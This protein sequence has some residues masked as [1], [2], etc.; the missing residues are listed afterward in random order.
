MAVL[1]VR[2]NNLFDTIELG[3]FKVRTQSPVRSNK[4]LLLTGSCKSM[5]VLQIVLTFYFYLGSTLLVA[6][7]R[8]SVIAL[9]VV[10]QLRP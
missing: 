1:C 2:K 10:F 7:V 4:P 9:A 5:L 8:S 6:T 3:P